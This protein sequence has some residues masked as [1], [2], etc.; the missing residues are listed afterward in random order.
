[1]SEPTAVTT[2]PVTPPLRAPALSEI[3]RALLEADFTVQLRNN[4]GLLLSF[5]LPLVVLYAL[6]ASKFYVKLGDREFRVAAALT[7]GMASIAILGYSMTVARD[8]EKG[9]FQ[10]LRVTPAPTWTIMTSRL[11]VQVVAIL[12]MALL[13][14]VAANLFESV[15]LTAGAYVLTLICVIFSSALFLGVGQALAGLVKSA[16]TLNAVGRIAYLP[17]F[18]LGLFGQSTIFGTTF[19]LISRWSPG[20]TVET[21]LS[22]AMNPSGWN[23]DTWLALAAC[24]AYSV[25]FAGIGIRWFQWGAR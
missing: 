15:S 5:A 20:G 14:L 2:P 9:V 18:A 7:L 17:L 3:F 13:V 4:R 19:E 6:F 21:L 10:R 22:G 8:R 1:M 16:D 11:L 24:A 23:S 25:V 12:L